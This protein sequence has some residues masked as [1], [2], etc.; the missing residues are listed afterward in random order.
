[1]RSF[2]I[3]LTA[4]LLAQL[5]PGTAGATNIRVLVASG[6]AVSVRVP[7]TPSVAQ[8]AA[9]YASWTVGALGSHLSLGGQDAG[10]DTLYLPPVP[11]STVDIDGHTYRGGLLLKVVSGVVKAVNVLD[12]EEYLL[13]VVP[14]EMPSSWPT[15]ALKSQAVIARTYA[16]AR[17]NPTSYYDLCATDSCQVYGGVA[18]ET[19][20]ASQAVQATRAQVVSYAGAAARTYFSSDSGGYT[21]S[22]LEAWGQDQP[23]LTAKPDPASQGPNSRWTLSV[24][25]SRVAEVAA[26]YGVQVGSVQSLTIT[27]LSASGRVTGIN[28]VGSAGSRLLS[29]A[30]AGG[31]VR[32]LGARSSR[33]N[34]SGSDP[35]VIEGAG[36]GHGVG[37]SQYGAAGLAR[38]GWNYLQIMGFYYAGASI[39]SILA[40]TRPGGLLTA[41]VPFREAQPA[42]LAERPAAPP[43]V[44]LDPWVL[45]SPGL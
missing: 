8:G 35:L 36:S 15:E 7:I 24:P 31:F 1:M 27:Q 19:A 3:L 17:I 18:R 14:A 23:Y 41:G 34:F 10:G 42:P 6:K 21:A 9:G 16:A 13:G 5:A 43:V 11:G 39:S 20:S 33:V 22:S 2:L 29:G 26:R 44:A 12:L 4:G 40:D 30:D 25:L 37:L 45:R 28:V 38:Q 32:S